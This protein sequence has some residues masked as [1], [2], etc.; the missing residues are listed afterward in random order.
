MPISL[1]YDF[2]ETS[3]QIIIKVNLKGATRSSLSTTI[4]DCYIKVN[5]PPHHFLELDL[6]ETIVLD[7]SS[8]THKVEGHN[9][10]FVLKKKDKKEWGSAILKPN[11]EVS[12]EMIESRRKESLERLSKMEAEEREER[13]KQRTKEE[14][15]LLELH[16]Q[17]E[18]KKRE[19]IERKKQEEKEQAALELSQLKERDE[20]SSQKS[21]KYRVA[22]QRQ[23]TIED[24]TEE[25][26]AVD[27]KNSNYE[28]FTAP[29]RQTETSTI[30]L[31]FTPRALRTPAREDKDS[32]TL[33]KYEIWRRKNKPAEL[34][35]NV[36]WVIERG[37]KFMKKKNFNSAISA[38][39]EALHMESSVITCLP[40]RAECFFERKEYLK[41]IEDCTNFLNTESKQNAQI[42]D[43]FLLQALTT[44]SK[45]YKEISDLKKA[46]EDVKIA[47]R[48][49][50]S[51]ELQ[52]MIREL[53]NTLSKELMEDKDKADLLK[54][55]AD[56]EYFEQRFEEAIKLYTDAINHRA[57]FFRAYSNRSVC[58]LQLNRYF[59][60]IQDC[61]YIL[62]NIHSKSVPEPEKK[63]A[64][65]FILKS[66]LRRGT[67]HFK[68]GDYNNSYK[69]YEQASRMAPEDEEILADLEKVNEELTSKLQGDWLKNTA[70]NFYLRG[71]FASAIHS[72]T[73]AVNLDKT[74]PVYY[75]NRAQCFFKTGDFVRCVKD[76]NTALSVLSE[77]DELK[78]DQILEEEKNVEAM[79]D[80]KKEKE[81]FPTN[82]K[83]TPK[84]QLKLYLKRAVAYKEMEE[85]ERAFLD[86]RRAHQLEPENKEIKS[87]YDSIE[88]LYELT[89]KDEI[90]IEIKE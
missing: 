7:D 25:D 40:K 76:C 1:L 3:E 67:C 78:V 47:Y 57:H 56:Q 11:D 5:C 69:D 65:S 79:Q 10:V 24:I 85:Y 8:R 59:E 70:N 83:L 63:N 48:I 62:Q 72:Y 31:S 54:D 28:H 77:D 38:Y 66:Y 52:K 9:V 51:I 36:V 42:E 74:N 35:E 15:R 50:S 21:E 17:E 41:A 19:D 53:E 20:T 71:D 89:K 26:I 23:V 14:Q 2:E 33:K 84:L 29:I 34:E 61:T 22:N 44:R 18:K 88:K 73:L 80:S 37:D 87:E 75:S 13:K 39:T 30:K 81:E 90:K 4:S 6:K 64:A 27:E 16:W 49:D 45:C 12:K 58:Y 82:P 55:Q 46:L 43:K 86:I 60:C 68:V 32:E